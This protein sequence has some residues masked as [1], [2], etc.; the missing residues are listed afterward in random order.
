M[1]QLSENESLNERERLDP[2]GPNLETRGSVARERRLTY[3]SEQSTDAHQPLG[4]LCSHFE[5]G[6][7]L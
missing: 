4:S 6:D 3:C 7:S 2:L 5:I 1:V